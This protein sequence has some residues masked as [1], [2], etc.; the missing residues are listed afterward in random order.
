LF[1]NLYYT[2]LSCLCIYRYFFTNCLSIYSALWA[3]S[4]FIKLSQFRVAVAI[5]WRHVTLLFDAVARTVTGRSYIQW[6]NF[7]QERR[8]KKNVFFVFLNM[9]K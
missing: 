6:A 3:A 1:I 9:L 4:M 8:M 7:E 5:T 2:V